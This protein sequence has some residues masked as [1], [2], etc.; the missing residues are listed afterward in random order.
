MLFFDSYGFV[1]FQ[2]EGD[3][4]N[5]TEMVRLPWCVLRIKYGGGS[6]EGRRKEKFGS[7]SPTVLKTSCDCSPYIFKGDCN[8]LVH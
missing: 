2:S 5:V 1:T 6:T 3:V 4:K 8:G 7:H